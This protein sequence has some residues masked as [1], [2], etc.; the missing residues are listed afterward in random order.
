MFLLILQ[1]A[2]YRCNLHAI[3]LSYQ[4]QP[5]PEVYPF[6]YFGETGWEYNYLPL[7]LK[8]IY[9]EFQVIRGV[10]Q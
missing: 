2:I 5:Y 4:C 10:S 9:P 8:G 1:D 7:K 6:K 3:F